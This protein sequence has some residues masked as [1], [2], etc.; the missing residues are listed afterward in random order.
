MIKYLVNDNLLF[1]RMLL[2]RYKH[3]LSIVK[4]KK[5]FTFPGLPVILKIQL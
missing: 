1:I 4:Y 5:Y 3:I 2:F